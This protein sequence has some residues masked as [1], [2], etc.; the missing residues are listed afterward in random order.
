MIDELKKNPMFRKAM[1][2]IAKR[3]RP[4]IP[5]FKA[6]VANSVDDWKFRSGQQQGFDLLYSILTGDTPDE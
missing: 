3:E 4:R 2:E 6:T 1:A 5:S